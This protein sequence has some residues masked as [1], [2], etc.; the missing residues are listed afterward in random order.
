MP[1]F[2]YPWVK[3]QIDL[4]IEAF[5][6]FKKRTGFTVFNTYQDLYASQKI[7]ATVKTVGSLLFVIFY[8]SLVDFYYIGPYIHNI[9]SEI[10]FLVKSKSASARLV[11]NKFLDIN[12]M[13]LDSMA[14]FNGFNRAIIKDDQ[15][16]LRG[17]AIL[18]E[19]MFLNLTGAGNSVEIM[20]MV[21]DHS[22]SKDYNAL[23]KLNEDQKK[24]P[25]VKSDVKIR[26]AKKIGDE[27]KLE[28]NDGSNRLFKFLSFKRATKRNLFLDKEINMNEY[29]EYQDEYKKSVEKLNNLENVSGVSG[30]NK[31]NKKEENNIMEV[32]DF[33][34][35]VT[36]GTNNNEANI[37]ELEF[38]NE[39][40]NKENNENN[41]NKENKNEEIKLTFGFDFEGGDKK[42]ESENNNKK[43]ENKNLEDA[44]DFSDNKNNDKKEEKPKT[45]I[46][47][48][49]RGL[50]PS[51]S[52]QNEPIAKIPK[53]QTVNVSKNKA[54]KNQLID[55]FD[56]SNNNNNNNN[57]NQATNNNNNNNNKNDV[58]DFNKMAQTNNNNNNNNNNN[59]GFDFSKIGQTNN[60]NNSGFDFSKIGQANN[61][62][63]NNN[64][65][66]GFDFSQIA[67]ANNNAQ[68][69][70]NQNNNNTNNANNNNAVQFD[71][72]KNSNNQ[73]N[74]N[75]PSN[76]TTTK[77]DNNNNNNNNLN[78]LL[79]T[80]NFPKEDTNTTT[81][82]QFIPS[83]PNNN[84]NNNNSNNNLN[85]FNFNNFNQVNQSDDFFSSGFQK[86]TTFNFAGFNNNMAFKRKEEEIFVDLKEKVVFCYK[87]TSGNNMVNAMGK[88]YLGL[89][90]K[91]PTISNKDFSISFKTDKINDANYI[92]N[93]FNKSM[94]KV[95]NLNYKIHFNS[96]RNSEPL[97]N[98]ILNPNTL[99][100]N[101]ILEPQI[102][103]DKNELKYHFYYNQN[104]KKEI[105]RIEI[106][107]LYKANLENPKM[108]TSDGVI[109]INNNN[110]ITV[111]YNKKIDEGKID[112]PNNVNVF[113]LVG[114]ITITVHL[115]EDVI[116]EMKVEIKDDNNQKVLKPKIETQISYDFS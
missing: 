96:F 52:N 115:N 62:N 43:E 69:S 65:N 8:S 38:W 59:T 2:N 102:G 78:D 109:T 84:T 10:K 37:K 90:T 42:G 88:G 20:N 14:F 55:F 85:G 22:G 40:E 47:K 56:F 23:I 44:F 26:E 61:N 49:K 107:I 63:K 9:I 33:I 3:N 79:S 53:I 5:K 64:N 103:G 98:Y 51:K 30:Q 54:N 32:F 110:S 24:K 111:I 36:N 86:S 89:K 31:D 75:N 70:N 77:Q 28:K 87:F 105:L 19:R 95:D 76:N 81:M 21:R 112:F 92:Q 101:R 116:S 7:K 100:E 13:M 4:Q 94:V 73:N 29:T 71:F 16:Y 72:S 34:N 113:A 99:A 25:K 41:G 108:T 46:D 50:S 68:Q 74:V 6:D 57:S 45:T 27:V 35:N 106:C 39:V 114:K 67:Q 80:F 12:T 1:E 17:E 82:T 93:D 66:S 18:N 91:G 48:N 97:L 104:V 83:F 60:N 15:K 11:H 58:F